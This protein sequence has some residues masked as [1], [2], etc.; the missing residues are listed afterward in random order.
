MHL[1][2][3]LFCPAKTKVTASEIANCLFLEGSYV[4]CKLNVSQV[5]CSLIPNLLSVYLF[6]A[7]K[8][9]SEG[10]LVIESPDNSLKVIFMFVS[11]FLY[12]FLYIKHVFM[13][14]RLEVKFVRGIINLFQ[15]LW[16][17][18]YIK[19]LPC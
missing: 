10:G 9:I 3:L 5:G 6:P 15:G 17:I 14:R 13:I 8:L 1:F 19:K 18:F 12:V 16:R 2:C 11:A 7:S 4:F